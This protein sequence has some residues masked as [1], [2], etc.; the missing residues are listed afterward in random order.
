MELTIVVA[1]V[2]AIYLVVSGAFLILKGKTLPLILDDFFKHPAVV[3]L[4]GVLLLFFGSMLVIGNSIPEGGW[5]TTA[6]VLG[7]LALLKGLMYIFAPDVL[8]NF[9]L[10]KFRGWFGAIGL[11]LIIAGIFLYRIG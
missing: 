7:W 6:N 11:V 2:F 8:A 10:K 9:P 1:K 3:Y 5:R 4:A